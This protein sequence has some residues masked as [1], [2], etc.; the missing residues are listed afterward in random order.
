MVEFLLKV[1]TRKTVT[2]LGI[3]RTYVVFERNA[4]S[5][6]KLILKVLETLV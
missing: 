3:N 2:L 4:F 5:L 6:N 1:D